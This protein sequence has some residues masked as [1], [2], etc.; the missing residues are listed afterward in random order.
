[1]ADRSERV[2]EAGWEGHAR[3]QRE[4]I[5]RLPLRDKLEWLEEAQTLVLHLTQRAREPDG[6][7][8]SRESSKR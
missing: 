6:R 1:M 2:W 3:A 8:P 5:A 7:E 4:R